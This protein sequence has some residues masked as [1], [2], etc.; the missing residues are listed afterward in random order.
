MALSRCAQDILCLLPDAVVDIDLPNK[1]TLELGPR[2]LSRA[3]LD[4]ILDSFGSDA[5]AE[6]NFETRQL[7]LT[8]KQVSFKPLKPIKSGLKGTTESER[9]A[10]QFADQMQV[11]DFD[12]LIPEFEL[13]S[14]DNH[15]L[16]HIKH[17]LCV[18]HNALLLQL[19][20]K[21]G[22][23]FDMNEC[24]VVVTFPKVNKRKRSRD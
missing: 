4:D 21:C 7:V 8:R 20:P 11:I 16:L 22:C 14:S 1:L 3:T 24:T 23:I 19:P 6:I 17:L 2:A 15:V 13:H 9:E 10:V 12:R 5:H 18:S